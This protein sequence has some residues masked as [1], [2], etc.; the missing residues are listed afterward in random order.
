MI[1]YEDLCVDCDYCIG[2]GCPY[3]KKTPVHYCDECGCELDDVYEV[4]DE[5]LCEECLK[6]R[7][8]L[9]FK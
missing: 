7:F 6:K 9:F 2:F 5:E 3:K 8:R 4:D 1:K